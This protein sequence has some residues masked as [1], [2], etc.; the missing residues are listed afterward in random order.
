MILLYIVILYLLLLHPTTVSSQNYL[1]RPISQLSQTRTIPNSL[2]KYI[3]C[4]YVVSR[5]SCVNKT[6]F[7]SFD[8]KAAGR[9]NGNR[10]SRNSQV[11][12]TWRSL[13]VRMRL[14]LTLRR[15]V[16]SL[17]LRL[18]VAVLRNFSQ[19]FIFCELNSIYSTAAMPLKIADQGLV[20]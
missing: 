19:E 13:F 5:Y 18:S 15:C 20:L 16:N 4:G 11:R 7:S 2:S 9:W 17:S 3:V 14:L 8:W 10:Q 12:T 6:N 1:L